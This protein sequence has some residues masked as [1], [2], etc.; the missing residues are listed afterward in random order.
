MYCV[1]QSTQGIQCGCSFYVRF[2]IL[3]QESINAKFECVS[4]SCCTRACTLMSWTK[5]QTRHSISCLAGF[6][7]PLQSFHSDMF[8]NQSWYWTSS[9]SIWCLVFL[10]KWKKTTNLAL[11]FPVNN[12][13]AEEKAVAPAPA[14]LCLA[15]VRDQFTPALPYSQLFFRATKAMMA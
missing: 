14:P 8:Q 1:Y 15:A 2:V 7:Q 6:Q 11:Q 5:M 12:S 9:T 3:C 4:S 10:V 13:E